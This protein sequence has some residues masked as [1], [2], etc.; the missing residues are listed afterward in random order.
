M[1]ID[2]FIKDV[3]TLGIT[4]RCLHIYDTWRGI[5]HGNLTPGECYHVTHIRM[6]SDYTYITLEGE[7]GTYSSVCFEFMID[8]KEHNIFTDER[9]WSDELIRRHRML[10]EKYG[11]EDFD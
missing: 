11:R 1:N 7:G 5:T 3:S 10:E 8:G 4:A 9:C 6:T 2:P